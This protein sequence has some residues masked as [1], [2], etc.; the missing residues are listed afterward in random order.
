[1]RP[2]V[3]GCGSGGLFNFWSVTSHEYQPIVAVLEFFPLLPP[4]KGQMVRISVGM[5]PAN[6]LVTCLLTV[7][8]TGFG[9]DRVTGMSPG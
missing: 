6:L 3:C 1:M 8:S 7:A 5:N 2:T 4:A 9:I